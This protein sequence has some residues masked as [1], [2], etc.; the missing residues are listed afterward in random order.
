MTYYAI[1]ATR[2]KEFEV[3]SELTEMGLH[4]WVPR[5]LASK[6]VKEKRSVVWYDRPYVGKLLFSIIPAIYYRDVF[7][8]K[9]VIG[10]PIKLNRLDIEGD[11]SRN[12]PG[13]NDF[14]AAVEAEYE[15]METR[16]KNREYR[17]QYEPGQ[18][19]RILDGPFADQHAVFREAIKREHDE[20]YKLR[21][22]MALM[23]RKATVEVDPNKVG[24]V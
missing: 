3:E 19:L 17:C 24:A 5:Q 20:Y 2:G 1:N 10:K 21:L 7:K 9:H 13:L 11:P 8:L 6:Y 14:K 18:A 12:A 22:E 15:D 23:G 16:K 4:P